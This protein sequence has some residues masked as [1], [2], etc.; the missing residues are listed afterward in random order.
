MGCSDA[1]PPQRSRKSSQVADNFAGGVGAGGAGEAVAGMGAGTAE[2]KAT[3]GCLVACPIEN[4]AHGEKLIECELAVENVAASKTVGCFE[5]LGRDDLD[6]FDH[7]GKIRGVSGE[8]FDDGRAEIPAAGI[9]VPFSQ[10]EWREL[11]VGGKNVLAVGGERGIEN[12]GNSDVEPGRF[13][14]FTVLGSVEGAL[15]VVNFRADVDA[16]G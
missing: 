2:K 12:R 6:A 8:S 9:P 10:F 7:A 15:E 4:R 14:K 3:D 16:A 1:R 13:R 11:D 5:I